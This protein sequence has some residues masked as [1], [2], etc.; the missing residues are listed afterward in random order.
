MK[1]QQRT[2]GWVVLAFAF[3]AV[4]SVGFLFADFVPTEFVHLPLVAKQSTP[5]PTQTPTPTPTPAPRLRDGDYVAHVT[6]D[7]EIW[8]TVTGNGTQAKN[9][10]FSF[11]RLY[12]TCGWVGYSWNESRPIDNGEFGF[13]TID[14]GNRSIVAQLHCTATSSTEADCHAHYWGAYYAICGSADAIAIRQ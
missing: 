6:Y 12:Y 13:V 9:G 4:V 2:I 14:Y 5:T 11:Q 3:V 7:G 8:F 10:G 1:A